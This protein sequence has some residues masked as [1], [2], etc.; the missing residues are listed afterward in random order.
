[1]RA[2]EVRAEEVLAEDTKNDDDDDDRRR[3]RI[4]LQIPISSNPNAR[5]KL[6]SS[7]S[8]REG[9]GVLPSQ[10]RGS[11]LFP[12]KSARGHK[13][14][15][16]MHACASLFFTSFLYAEIGTT[17]LLISQRT[18]AGNAS[19]DPIVLIAVPHLRIS[20]GHKGRSEHRWLI[21]WN[22]D[23]GNEIG[24]VS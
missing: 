10:S 19:F 12:T 3:L 20:L 23:P 18:E 13:R 1:M 9:L 22:F 7:T 16:W 24:R 4:V 15:R 11:S 21:A 2:E 14:N 8:E 5:S 17:G 6:L